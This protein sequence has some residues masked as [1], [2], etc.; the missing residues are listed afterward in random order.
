MD[1]VKRSLLEFN[2][3]YKPES[4]E[5]DLQDIE[6]TY[7]NAGGTFEVIE[8]DRFEIIGTVALFKI[9]D[10]TAKLRKMYVDKR[11]RGAGL[12]KVLMDRALS[13]AEELQFEDIILETVHDM[14]A[15]IRLYKSYGFREIDGFTA[16]SPRCDVIMKRQKQITL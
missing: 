14:K 13:K 2:L 5:K 8:S 4:S 10:K 7:M 1:L 11:F 15:A 12:G 9:D 3:E 6:G 16:D